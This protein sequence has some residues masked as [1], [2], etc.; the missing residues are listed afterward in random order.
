[1]TRP[2]PHVT[3]VLLI[4]RARALKRHV[5]EAV[6]GDGTG[7]HQARVASRRLREAVP[8]LAADVKGSRK[9]N[10]QRKIRRLTQ[11]LG[12]VRELDVTL[13]ILDDMAQ[14]ETFPRAALEDVRGR[15]INARE[16]GRELMLK[17]LDRI[18]L[19]KLDR[20]LELVAGTLD[21]QRAEAWREVLARRLLKRAKRLA[22]AI[23]EAGHIYAPERLHVVRI[24]VKKL[25]YSTELAA[26]AG[27][28]DAARQLATLKR[29]QEVL[30][31]LH[32]LQ[33]LQTHVAAVQADPSRRSSSDRGLGIISA[34]LE[35]ECRYLHGRYV[36]LVPSLR[37]VAA[38]TRS[39]LVPQLTRPARA[40]RPLKMGL[41][42]RQA[43]RVRAA[44]ARR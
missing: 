19:D 24:A 20:R 10:A 40:R 44:E 30:G 31:R 11:A 39:S 15:V 8:V 38:S 29:A 2:K 26:E 41:A 21:T 33:V 3:S 18:R 22:S 28:R 12:Q 43:G 17:R 35:R 1:M 4:R 25:R 13:A 6:K 16:E 37:A 27:H 14:R 32:D 36:A 9:G 23:E 5:A 7:V 42:P 34:A